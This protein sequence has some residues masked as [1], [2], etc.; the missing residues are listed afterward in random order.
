MD[1][2]PATLAA[3]VLT[4]SLD[5]EAQRR[6][7]NAVGRR[8]GIR[9]FETLFPD[10]QAGVDA[11]LDAYTT[12]ATTGN[13]SR[14]LQEVI[15]PTRIRVTQQTQLQFNAMQIGVFRL[16]DAKRDE[17]EAA[18]RYLDT[19]EQHWLARIRLETLILGRMPQQRFGIDTGGGFSGENSG[20]NNEASEGGH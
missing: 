11:E 1:A 5:L 18:E 10:L 15:L 4:A 17:I 8:A 12:A 9:S 19:L 3:T 7:I 2:D 6:Q 20:L 14:Y 16:L 13:T